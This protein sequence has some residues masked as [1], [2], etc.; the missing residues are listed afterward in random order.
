VD[1]QACLA[2][3]TN[4]CCTELGQCIES[5]EQ[6]DDQCGQPGS[7]CKGC[8]DEQK[9]SQWACRDDPVWEIYV[10]ACVVAV[11]QSSGEQWDGGNVPGAGEPDPMVEAK[12]EGDFFFSTIG[13]TIEDTTTPD[14][15]AT[16]RRPLVG[17]E[18]ALRKGVTFRIWDA[19]LL[20]GN[21]I[22]ECTLQMPP[23]RLS[24]G[25]ETIARCGQNATNMHL[26]YSRR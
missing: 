10:D 4:G 20:F 7:I 12:I 24:G 3:C 6:S 16:Q 5:V 26:R 11:R 21:L 2:Y 15:T 17:T 1:D 18:N 19:D 13:P 25:G 23:E 14:F 8:P 9:C 22:G